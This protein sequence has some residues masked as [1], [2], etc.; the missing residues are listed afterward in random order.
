M[1]GSREIVDE[2][3]KQEKARE[4]AEKSIVLL[5]EVQKQIE[6][7]NEPKRLSSD[8]TTGIRYNQGKL[9]YDLVPVFAQEQ[10][11]KVLTYGASKY[12][13]DNWRKGL[14]WMSCVAS[15]ERHLASFK[16]GEDI[17]P[18]SGL[19]HMAHVMCNAA[20]LSEFAKTHPELD[21]RI[22]Y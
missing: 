19:P 2:Y 13:Q 7:F 5:D 15:L 3:R 22:K 17:D 20:F 6:K 4:N 21:D 12:S 11:V 18:E 16:S 8:T 9:R 1:S 10:Y 14:S